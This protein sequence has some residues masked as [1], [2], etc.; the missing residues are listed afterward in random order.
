MHERFQRISLISAVE[1]VESCT[2][3]RVTVG[4]G[5]VP[6]SQFCE[7][8][9]NGV[10]DRPVDKRRNQWRPIWTPWLCLLTLF[11]GPVQSF[12]QADPIGQSGTI[13]DAF[14]KKQDEFFERMW[15]RSTPEEEKAFESIK[16]SP[17]EE[18]EFGRAQVEAFSDWLNQQD[19][20]IVRKGADVEYLRKLVELI[21][22][23]MEHRERYRKVTVYVV[24][25]SRVDARTFPG[26]TLFFFRGLL[27]AAENEAALVG[28]VG[29]ELSHL[30][31]GH[32]LIPLKRN[33]LL[34][35]QAL[36]VELNPQNFL[37]SQNT[38]MRSFTRPFHPEDESAADRDGARWAY[39]A[40]YDSREMAR[41]FERLHHQ[42][43]DPKLPFG[44]FFR[45]HPYS[46]DRCAAILKQYDELQ[47]ASPRD[48]PYRGATNLAKRIP[49]SQ[50]EF[51]E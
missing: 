4:D 2:Q 34:Q 29:H 21:R 14:N 42:G 26:G 28:I 32:L 38:L 5:S 36:A 23:L 7:L 50:Q 16:V 6:H 47:R 30:D 33:K 40:G 43:Q 3:N 19:L 35:Q 12:A 31:R 15:G 11:V 18:R 27:A 20:R 51:A 1:F 46:D 25:S 39:K 37:T 48:E 44:Q 45:T 17:E 41:L 22:P 8:G 9:I 10:N 13:L 49:R 24:D